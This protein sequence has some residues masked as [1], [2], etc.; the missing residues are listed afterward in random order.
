VV[1]PGSSGN[2]YSIYNKLGTPVTL[3]VPPICSPMSRYVT[4]PRALARQGLGDGSHWGLKVVG[5]APDGGQV[6]TV[7]L[8]YVQSTGGE[9]WSYYPAG[10]GFGGV[11]LG[12]WDRSGGRRWGNAVCH[13]MEGGGVSY[14]LDM[15]NTGEQALELSLRVVGSQLLADSLEVRVMEPGSGLM[16]DVGGLVKVRLEAGGSAQ[17][18]VS[19]GGE[20]FYRGA[21]ATV[22]P[23]SQLRAYPNPF[24]GAVAIQFVVPSDMGRV[25]LRLVDMGGRLVWSRRMDQLQ[26]GVNRV[27][28]D[29]R[30]RRGEQLSAAGFYLL[31]VSAFDQHGQRVAVK[32]QKL[33]RMR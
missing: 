28:W 14:V 30:G 25:E 4:V 31:Q 21:Y 10:P 1:L 15:R 33:V 13:R 24:R 19:V 3:R 6:G 9:A 5:Y 2:V 27:V 11:S 17:R 32:Q 20:S 29:G 23:L 12:V 16:Q 7:I 26:A 18:G 8:G 22:K